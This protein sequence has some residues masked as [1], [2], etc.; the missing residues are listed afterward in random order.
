MS[1]TISVNPPFSFSAVVQSHGWVQLAPNRYVDGV[2]HTVDEL[3][4]GR[5]VAPALAARADGVKVTLPDD[6]DAD[7]RAT[8]VARMR[9]MLDLERDLSGFY[10]VAQHEP[11]LAHVISS[12]SGRMLRSP[13]LFEDV[14]KTILTTNT[15]WSGTKRMAQALVEQFGAPLA[16]DPQ[17]RA[18]PTAA[19]LAQVSAETLRTQTRLGYRAPY[20]VA[21]S[22]AVADGTLDLEAL[23]AADHPT[24][25]LRRR[26]MT[27]KGVGAYAAANLL[28]LLGR[29]DFI[30]IDSAARA[31]VSQEWHGGAPVSEKQIEAAFADWGAYKGLA[32][33][34][35]DW[36]IRPT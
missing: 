33:W 4:S 19:R 25:E 7:E 35:W 1:L 28:M 5:V 8:A 15:A 27:I 24:P 29:S 16:D 22:R 20:I 3:P 9:W 23:K 30:P 36:S 21:L 6:L 14:V 10:A 34:F 18:F 32:Y 26:L 17:R 13:T 11:K 31:S 2:L 12:R